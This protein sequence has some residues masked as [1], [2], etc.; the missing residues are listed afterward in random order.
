MHAAHND[1]AKDQS[2]YRRS[3]DKAGNDPLDNVALN[4][5]CVRDSAGDD[6]GRIEGVMLDG[7]RERIMYAILSLEGNPKL[8]AVPWSVLRLNPDEACVFLDIPRE[9]LEAAPGFHRDSWPSITDP[10]WRDEVDTYYE[11]PRRRR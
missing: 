4:G 5:D 2:R 9:H 1:H 8:F 3:R 11:A 7:R 6:V 10:V